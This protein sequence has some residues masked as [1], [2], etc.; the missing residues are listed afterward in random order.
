MQTDEVMAKAKDLAR[1][2]DDGLY[3]LREAGANHHTQE[4]FATDLI[5]AALQ[6]QGERVEVLEKLV[7]GAM[8]NMSNAACH[9]RPRWTVVRDTF[10]VGS[11]RANELCAEYDL[12][13]DGDMPSPWEREGEGHD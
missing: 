9:A 8:H 10:G 11:T 6:A 3:K 5:A 4:Q 12:N 7:W 1:Q 13:P 2:I